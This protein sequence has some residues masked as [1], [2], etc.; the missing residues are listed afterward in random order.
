M[1]KA[2]G[3]FSNVCTCQD[4]AIPTLPPTSLTSA[5]ND[6]LAPATAGPLPS[7]P[8][9]VV[10]TLVSTRF[11]RLTWRPPASDPQGDN[12]TYSIFYTKEGIN[13]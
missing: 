2:V 1:L 8:R 6:H 3:E 12:L 13:R 4:V 11:I 10:A 9:D 5:T 7:A